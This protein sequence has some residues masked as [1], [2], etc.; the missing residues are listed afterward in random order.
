MEGRR[1]VMLDEQ[2]DIMPGLLQRRTKQL[3][4][5]RAVFDQQDRT[6]SRH[7]ERHTAGTMPGVSEMSYAISNTYMSMTYAVTVHGLDDVMVRSVFARTRGKIQ[8]GKEK[9]QREKDRF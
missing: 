9:F 2:R 3:A 8:G 5:A 7:R 4:L 1:G 6:L